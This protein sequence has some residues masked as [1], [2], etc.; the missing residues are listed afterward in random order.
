MRQCAIRWLAGGASLMLALPASAGP[1]GG[2][3]G[4]LL[5]PMTQGLSAFIATVIVFAGVYFVLSKKAW[6]L[7]VKGLAEREAKIKAEIESAEL[8]RQQAKEALADYERSLAE[9]RAEAKRMLD[10]TKAQQQSLAAE[11]RTKADAELAMMK[12]RARRDIDIAKKAAIAEIYAEAG[13]LAAAMAS[14]ILR[15]EVSQSDYDR[16]MQESLS[17]LRATRN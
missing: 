8:A 16:L 10:E 7:I 5:A 4:E 12:E 17:E 15:R 6:P 2:E 1:E 14:K 11:L 3:N 9:A 13:D